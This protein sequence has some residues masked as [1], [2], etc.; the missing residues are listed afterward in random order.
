MKEQIW[1]KCKIFVAVN[2]SHGHYTQV[3]TVSTFIDINT[4][5]K[6]CLPK[7]EYISVH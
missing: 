7:K 2:L 6:I 3:C 1:L 4:E 5:N